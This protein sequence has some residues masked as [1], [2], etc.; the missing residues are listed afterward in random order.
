M[1]DAHLGVT[2][3]EVEHELLRFFDH[4]EGRARSLVIN[5]D[6]FDF[7]FEWRS[8]IPR[9]G[10]RVV[11]SLGR[12]VDHGTRV[13]WIAGNHDCWGGDVLRRDVGVEYH[14]GEW[15]GEIAEWVTRIDHGDGLRAVEDRRYRLLRR[16]LRHRLSVRAF[17]LLHPDL[18]MRI[19]LGSSHAS[20]SY[21][22]RDG[23]AGLREV[24]RR[25]LEAEPGVELLVFGH[26]HVP[27][28]EQ[29]PGAGVYANA[30]TW[31]DDTTYLRIDESATELRRWKG[32]GGGGDELVTR[33]ARAA[34]SR[35]D[36]TSGR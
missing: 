10:F 22:A 16:V 24:A 21:R 4:L 25:A 7:W 30:G 9:T 17:R 29:I 27:V 12:L 13:L 26:S 35:P 19:A 28:L 32:A 5:G 31:M 6:L 15:R 33:A 11:A 3:P 20:R 8:V 18:G 2:P 23:G 14:V 36:A 1:S 34:R